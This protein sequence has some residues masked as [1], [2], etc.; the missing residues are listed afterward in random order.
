MD[1][2]MGIAVLIAVVGAV[3]LFVFKQDK[4]GR[5]AL[6]YTSAGITVRA[7]AQN[8][9][10]DNYTNDNKKRVAV[11]VCKQYLAMSGLKVEDTLIELA[12]EAAVKGMKL[13]SVYGGELTELTT[14][15]TSLIRNE[16][17]AQ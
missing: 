2:V 14:D 15:Y 12:I 1:L 13:A 7:V 10:W 5:I 8:P 3:G 9:E 6:L 17:A 4:T 16:G 11:D